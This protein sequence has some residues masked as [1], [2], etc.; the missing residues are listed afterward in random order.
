[1]PLGLSEDL[2]VAVETP[3][4]ARDAKQQAAL[5]K[6]LSTTDTDLR[7]KREG[8]AA[9]QMPLPAD[10]KLAALKAAVAEANKPIAIDPKLLQLRLDM[11]M[12]AK[13][14]GNPRLTGA[15]DV[16]WALVN[17]PAFLFNH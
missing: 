10:P 15:Q 7:A 5:A 2:L 9:A 11:A 17:S 16:V 4:A 12:S 6:Y 3:A 8:V 13:Q 14:V 1:V